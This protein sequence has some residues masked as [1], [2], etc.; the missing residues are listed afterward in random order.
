MLALG[1]AARVAIRHSS[2]PQPG[3]RGLSRQHGTRQSDIAGASIRVVQQKTGAA[4]RV[5]I[6]RADLFRPVSLMD[7]RTEL[8]VVAHC[9]AIPIR[10]EKTSY[11]LIPWSSIFSHLTSNP[12]V[13][14]N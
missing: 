3:S 9:R 13:A 2:A 14:L 10:N 6:G 5:G 8:D 11:S 1:H 12:A 4:V 7:V